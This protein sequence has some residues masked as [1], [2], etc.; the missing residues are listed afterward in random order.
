V[1]GVRVDLAKANAKVV[2][3][4][5]RVAWEAKAPKGLLATGKR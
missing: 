4:L 5:L 1:A 3:G 2:G